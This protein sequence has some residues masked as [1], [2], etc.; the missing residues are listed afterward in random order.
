[1]RKKLTAVALTVGIAAIAA[2][3]NLQILADGIMRK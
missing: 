3:P 2:L 1:M